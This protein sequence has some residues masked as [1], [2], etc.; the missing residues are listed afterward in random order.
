MPA[1]RTSAR[2]A[3]LGE[4]LRLLDG[5]FD[6]VLDLLHGAF[7]VALGLIELS[8]GLELLVAGRCAGRL[9]DLA[10][11]LVDDFAHG[12]FSLVRVVLVML[13]E[14]RACKSAAAAVGGLARS[15]SMAIGDR[16]SSSSRRPRRT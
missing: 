12:V 10:F 15:S 4:P 8:L 14:R 3:D 11:D 7:H 16:G 13:F 9:L 5:L 6:G 2:A 1:V